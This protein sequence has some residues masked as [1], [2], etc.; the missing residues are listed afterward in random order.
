MQTTIYK[1]DNKVLRDSTCDYIQDLVGT[2]LMV[3]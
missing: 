1:I 2:F 3:Q